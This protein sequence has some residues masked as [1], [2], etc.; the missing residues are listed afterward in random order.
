[1]L[2]FCG[3]GYRDDVLELAPSLMTL[4]DN[5]IDSDETGE[6][7]DL[8]CSIYALNT[9]FIL[10]FTYS[11]FAAYLSGERPRPKWR[12]RPHLSRIHSRTHLILYLSHSRI[13]KLERFES[14]KHTVSLG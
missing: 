11:T 4:V 10:T 7:C 6:L 2:E 9:F 12:S 14:L 13:H 3:V 5:I 1:M 8:R